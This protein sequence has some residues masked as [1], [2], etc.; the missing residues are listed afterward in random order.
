ME[1]FGNAAIFYHFDTSV[2]SIETLK[3]SREFGLQG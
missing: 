1:I 3:F 2:N